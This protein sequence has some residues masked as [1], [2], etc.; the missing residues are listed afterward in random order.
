MTY[1]ISQD[2]QESRIRVTKIECA[3]LEALPEDHEH[4]ELVLALLNVA[5]RLQNSVLQKE[6]PVLGKKE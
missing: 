3:I 2:Y 1:Q 5:Q 4:T 6:C